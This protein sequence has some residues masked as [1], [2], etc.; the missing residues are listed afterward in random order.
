[1]KT[2][3]LLPIILAC[4][5]QS[6]H[7]V[8]AEASVDI[9]DAGITEEASTKTETKKSSPK[10]E[11]IL[12]IGDSEVLYL[13]WYWSKAKLQR[14]NET[15]L[16]DSKPGTTIGYWNYVF[17]D[18]MKKYPKVDVV[19]IF[20]GTNNHNF[21]N[22]MQPH[23]H[24]LDEVKRRNIPCIWAGGTSV[25][26]KRWEFNQTLRK[27]VEASGVCQFFNTEEDD[28][29]LADQIHPSVKG[30]VKWLQDI[31]KVKDNMR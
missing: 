8:I 22:I 26:G 30:A 16:F 1:M 3:Y 28:I 18:E 12:L 5:N 13:S 29:E 7:N 19:L 11:D 9:V 6:A 2:I 20:L 27:M 15:V 25:Y 4:H 31:W 21:G 17:V 14:E 24:I 10:H 23:Q